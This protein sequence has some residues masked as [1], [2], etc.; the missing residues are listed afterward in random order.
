M[1]LHGPWKLH[2]V[3]LDPGA[4]TTDANDGDSNVEDA[5]PPLRFKVPGTINYE[6][7]E[8]F[9]SSGVTVRFKRAF[10]KP[11][12]LDDDQSLFLI[13][14]SLSHDARISLYA[15]GDECLTTSVSRS[16]SIGR[17]DS[18][19]ADQQAVTK[20]DVTGLLEQRNGLVIEMSIESDALSAGA[21]QYQPIGIDGE[22]RLEI[23]DG[24]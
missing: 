2:V 18:E 20:L 13:I 16:D 23:V 1:R 21:G 19:T 9:A 24:A 7:L 4:A 8:P 17:F 14:E 3:P 12:G 10:G 5:N 15:A 22:V 11:T 6:L